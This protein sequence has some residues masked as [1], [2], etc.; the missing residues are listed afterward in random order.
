[1]QDSSKQQYC[2]K[3]NNHKTNISGVFDRLRSDE[4]FVDVTLSSADQKSLKCHRVLLSAGSG[5]LEKILEQNPSDHPTIVLS[6]IKFNELKYLVE[7]MYSGEVAVEQDHLSKLLE[8]ANI[9]QIK[10]LYESAEVPSDEKISEESSQI[11]N[12]AEPEMKTKIGP[13]DSELTGS[14]KRKK[15]K[16]TSSAESLSTSADNNLSKKVKNE[17][18]NTPPDSPN[19]FSP[20]FGISNAYFLSQQQQSSITAAATSAALNNLKSPNS[21]LNSLNS[22]NKIIKDIPSLLSQ[23]P[24]NPSLIQNLQ[25]LTANPKPD[26]V[27]RPSSNP[28]NDAVNLNND[29]TKQPNIDLSLL[30]NTPVRRYKQYTEDTLQH[31]LK[32]IMNG[33]SINRSSMKYNIPARTLRDWMKRLNIKSVFTHHTHKDGRSLSADSSDYNSE[34]SQ[35]LPPN[36]VDGSNIEN[37]NEVLSTNA[38][39]TNSNAFPGMKLP[40]IL[41]EI[42]RNSPEILRNGG[43]ID[44]H[45][46]TEEDEEEID[47]DEDA[48]LEEISNSK[49][50][51][52]T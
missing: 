40:L 19:V 41:P 38:K 36:E 29:I 45:N 48:G 27:Q 44:E 39:I 49:T 11:P 47:D 43:S 1:M 46:S 28:A 18:S 2:L 37:V 42:I 4:K 33:Q 31:A 13:K 9:L 24:L 14:Q 15:R 50:N 22:P 21:A 51:T 35:T 34:E 12:L 16:S 3:W 8:A 7:F 6:H 25:Q 30:C 26:L 32:E 23:H 5:Y 17:D 52:K 20:L 10:G